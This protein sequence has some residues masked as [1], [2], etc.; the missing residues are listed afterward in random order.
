MADILE[1]LYQYD[2]F[3]R[4]SPVVPGLAGNRE[5][6][7]LG[8]LINCGALVLG[9][10]S[11][12][13]LGRTLPAR[14]KN[15]LPLTCGILSASI[16]TTLMNKVHATPAVALA[17]LA[18]A[19][20]GELLYLERGLELSI[21]WAQHHIERIL[22]GEQGSPRAQGFIAKYVTILVLFCASG[23][24]IFGSIHEGMTHDANIL[25]AKS[26]L[27]LFT[28]VI[29][30]AE[31]GASVTLI[32]I[33]QV[34]IQGLLYFSAH[35]VVPLTTPAMLA[36]FSAAGGVIMLATGLRICGIKIFPI[37]NMLPAL[38]LILPI[39]AVWT[40]FFG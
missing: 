31:M 8:P 26:V 27:D 29:F 24:G 32:A 30:A 37:V 10:V 15:A 7:M 39:S 4:R 21:A 9:G 12:T 19:C 17:L 11:G 18:G 36:D 13:L 6:A 14:I 34:L 25:M 22:P 3:I 40:H 20:I 33:P 1:K 38:A 23:M 28:A 2:L 35:L 16:G 5:I